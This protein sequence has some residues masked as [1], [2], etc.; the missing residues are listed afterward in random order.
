[1]PPMP[2]KNRPESFTP[3]SRLKSD[4]I[5]SPMTAAM[6]NTTPRMSACVRFMP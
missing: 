4:S 2:G 1:M 5:K 3:A 6:L